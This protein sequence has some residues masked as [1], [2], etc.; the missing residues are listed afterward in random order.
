MPF[1]LKKVSLVLAVGGISISAKQTAELHSSITFDY[2]MWNHTHHH[3]VAPHP[4]WPR[5]K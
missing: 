3:K 5:R 4:E 2:K 1:F